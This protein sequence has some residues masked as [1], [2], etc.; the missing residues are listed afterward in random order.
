MRMRQVSGETPKIEG[1]ARLL[2][3]A[4]RNAL[5]ASFQILFALLLLAAVIPIDRP[6]FLHD[7]ITILGHGAA[8]L[9]PQALSFMKW[10][11]IIAAVFYIL[12]LCPVLLISIGHVLEA[13]ELLV[14][15]GSQP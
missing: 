14:D 13:R 10:S 12:L 7:L 15:K 2:S 4:R 6:G 5:S 11:F 9:S 1:Q 3:D 8:D